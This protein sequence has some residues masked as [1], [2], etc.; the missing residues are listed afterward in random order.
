[1]VDSH[2][3]V[4]VKSDFVRLLNDKPVLVVGDIMLDNYLI[5]VSDRI[6][7][8]APVPIVKIENEKIIE[9]NIQL[10]QEVNKFMKNYENATSQFQ[11]SSNL[12]NTQINN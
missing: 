6:S 4:M 1:M 8:E 10:K 7:P 2:S 3:A 9:E 5:G 12:K 11:S